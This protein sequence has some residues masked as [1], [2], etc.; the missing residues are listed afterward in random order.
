M[1]IFHERV[2]DGRKANVYTR[3]HQLEI[4]RQPKDTTSIKAV[5]EYI[6]P[7]GS[8]VKVDLKSTDG[9][10]LN[11]EI[12]QDEYRLLSLQKRE[13]VYVS[14]RQVTYYEFDI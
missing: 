5:V 3:P 8:V 1:N 14:M 12:T 9:N 10:V 11:A 6:N 4:T 2:I 7:A 13:E